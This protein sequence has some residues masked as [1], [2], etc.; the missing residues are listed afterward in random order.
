MGVVDGNKPAID[1]DWE[2]ITKKGDADIQK[3]IDG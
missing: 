2:A 1:N 3:W